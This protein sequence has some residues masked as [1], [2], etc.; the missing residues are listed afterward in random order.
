MITITEEQF[1]DY[2]ELQQS[3]ACNMLDPMVRSVCDLTRDEH[4]ELMSNYD[5]LR[6]KYKKE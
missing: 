1:N 2:Y 4:I 5:E 6:K 3:G